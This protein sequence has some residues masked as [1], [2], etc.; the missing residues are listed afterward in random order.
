MQLKYFESKSN[1]TSKCNFR[2]FVEKYNF[3]STILHKNYF[4]VT[5]QNTCAGSQLNA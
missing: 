2:Y 5:D 4:N 3:I 1:P